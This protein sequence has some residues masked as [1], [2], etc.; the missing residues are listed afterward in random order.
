M[1]SIENQVRSMSAALF[2]FG[3]FIVLSVWFSGCGSSSTVSYMGP[4][5]A[6]GATGASEPVPVVT[7]VDAI[8]NAYNENLVGT[9]NDPITPG[10]R[11][12]LYAVPNMPAEPCLLATNIPGCATLS[13]S[14]G[15]AYVGT[16][17]YTG[18]VNQVNQVGAQGFNMLPTALQSSY[19]NNFAITCTGYFVNTDY[20][21]HQFDVSSDDGSLLYV[22]GGNPL[23]SNDGLHVAADVT[24][25]VYLQAQVYYFQLN[26]FQGGGNVALTVNMD[27]NL[28]PAAN[29]YH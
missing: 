1:K 28:L 15:Y 26:Y 13:G 21:Y 11:C 4:T 23:V 20:N 9:G 2:A 22:G 25:V 29:L 18:T 16:W 24:G 6:T 10:L 12:S 3:I 27:G 19:A 17:T 14:P 7:S 5:G 8:V